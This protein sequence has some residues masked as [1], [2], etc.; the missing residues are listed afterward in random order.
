MS[1]GEA[2][3]LMTDWETVYILG[4]TVTFEELYPFISYT[5]AKSEK[6]SARMKQ[7]LIVEDDTTMNPNYSWSHSKDYSPSPSR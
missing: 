3:T 7:I 6:G 2:R 1:S 5:N 4:K